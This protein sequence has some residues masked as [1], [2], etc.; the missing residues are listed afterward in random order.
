MVADCLP[1]LLAHLDLPVVA[2]AHAGWRGLAGLGAGG[3]AGSSAGVLG[4]VFSRFADL[5]WQSQAQ[6][7]RPCAPA[8]RSTPGASGGGGDARGGFSRRGPLR[9]WCA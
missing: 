3:L 5:A 7:R 1:V 6:R 9:R 4:A 8:R 2:A